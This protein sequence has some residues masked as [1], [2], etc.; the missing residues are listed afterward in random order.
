MPTVDDPNDDKS[1]LQSA[2]EEIS[3]LPP[4]DAKVVRYWLNNEADSHSPSTKVNHISHLLT[5]HDELNGG[6]ADANKYDWTNAIA[7][8]DDRRDWTSGTKLPE[9]GAVVVGR[10]RGGCSR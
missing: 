9:V 4:E 8:L 10:H 1:R 2:R 5:I 7:A 6:F 3:S